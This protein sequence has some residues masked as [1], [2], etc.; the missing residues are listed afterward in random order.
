MAGEHR[1]YVGYHL[2]RMAERRNLRPPRSSRR[3]SL[4]PE[5]SLPKLQARWGTEGTPPRRTTR[6]SGDERVQVWG[7]ARQAVEEATGSYGDRPVTNRRGG[8]RCPL[9]G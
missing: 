9:G 4:S 1:L 3:A 5:L 2:A 7:E 6:L 8:R